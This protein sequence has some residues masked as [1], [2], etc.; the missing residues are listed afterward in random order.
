VNIDSWNGCVSAT[1]L[2][3]QSMVTGNMCGLVT[4][5]SYDDS[6][7]PNN[8]IYLSNQSGTLVYKDGSGNVNSL[9]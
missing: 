9:Y 1:Y 7:A 5:P 4:P 3:A 8:S 2:C 6:S